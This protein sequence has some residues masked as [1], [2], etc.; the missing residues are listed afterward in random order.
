MTAFNVGGLLGCIIGIL[1]VK[2]TSRRIM[3]Y[4]IDILLIIG[5]LG[6]NI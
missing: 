3:L 1:I 5:T 4:I 2:S 6:L